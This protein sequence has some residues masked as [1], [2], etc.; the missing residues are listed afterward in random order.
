M[1]RRWFQRHGKRK[2]NHEGEM[3]RCEGR[4]RRALVDGGDALVERAELTAHI[5][6]DQ[7][8]SLCRVRHGGGAPYQGWRRVTCK[9][10]LAR[11]VPAKLF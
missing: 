4:A 5:S 9:R 7:D 2:H 8:L 11:R 6:G 3:K 1:R 10:A